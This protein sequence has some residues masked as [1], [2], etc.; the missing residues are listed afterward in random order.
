MMPEQLTTCLLTICV[1]SLPIPIYIYI[2]HLK[3][4]IYLAALDL[5]CGTRDLVPRPGIEP[6]FPALGMQSLSHRTIR[7]VPVGPFLN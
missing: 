3:I 6:A 5:S 7:E 1:F 2:M 4:L